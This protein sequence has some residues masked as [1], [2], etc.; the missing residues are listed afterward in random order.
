MLNNNTH[1]KD[2]FDIKTNQMSSCNISI[3]CRKSVEST[4]L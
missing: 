3:S 4:I 2:Q 1:N